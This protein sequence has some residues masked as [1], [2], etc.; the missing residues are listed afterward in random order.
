MSPIGAA[1]RGFG[2]VLGSPSVVLWLWLVNVVVA[3]P[4]A[5]VV[6][7]SLGDSIGGSLVDE[8]LREGFDMGWYGEY[9][10]NAD[11]I[12]R[13][14]TPTIV[15]A[16]AFFDNLEAWYNGNLFE[17]HPGL[18][19]LGILY[20]LAWSLF[21]GGVL[22]RYGEAAGLFRLTEFL[23]HGATYF[24]RFIRLAVLSAV[25]YYAIYRFSGWLFRRVE[26]ATQDVTVEETVLA[27]VVMA[28]LLV[29]FLLTFVN[30]AF[31]YAKIATFR[32][33]RRSMILASLKGFGF[34]LGNLGR[35]MTLYYGLGLA[36]VLMLFA[37]Y[38]V[39]PDAGQSTILG[40]LAAFA[41]GQLYLIAKLAL[42][43]T[44][45]ASQMALFDSRSNRGF[46]SA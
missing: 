19:G 33:N 17:T 28:S 23:S 11:G 43:L 37:Y 3:L 30:M 8:K 46:I 2:Q 38:T 22:H 45:Y 42:R 7:D 29:L 14:F 1:F 5:A 25:F 44:F 9:R 34:A 21:L 36:G 27:Y 41:L 40:V 39:A 12:G 15:G 24:F 10:A 26:R 13:T 6:A 18:M 4:A 31:D 35:T 20:A 16:G 32:E